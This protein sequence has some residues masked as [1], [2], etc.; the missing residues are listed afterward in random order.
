M[1]VRDARPADAAAV[2]RVH[3][4]A[5]AELGPEAYDEAQVAAWGSSDPSDYDLAGGDNRFVVAEI[6]GEVR[7]F[8]ELA[9]EAGDYLDPAADAEVKAVY[10]HPAAVRRGVGSALLAELERDARESGFQTVGLWASRNAVPFYERNEY[11]RVAERT[12]EFGGEVE[13][14]VVE[15]RKDLTG[16]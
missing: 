4:D 13:G 1:D 3:L 6:D 16:D 10:V 14:S 11:E 2:N 5:V 8:G 9:Y 12:H 7:G 15:F